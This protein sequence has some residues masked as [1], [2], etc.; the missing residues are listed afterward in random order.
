MLCSFASVI[1]PLLVITASFYFVLL[2]SGCRSTEGI[3]QN[4][5]TNGSSND[6]CMKPSQMRV[7]TT[8][9]LR[10][11]RLVMK[12]EGLSGYIVPSE[13]E[14][15]SEFVPD[16]TKRRQYISGFS[17]SAGMA[18]VLQE[19][20][21]VQTDSRYRVQAAL[22]MDCQWT[23][24]P[25]GA[26][27]VGTFAAMI[28]PDDIARGNNRIGVD[29]CLVT[30]E[31][32]STL[33]GQ[34]EKH[35]LVLVG[36]DS[37]LIDVIWTSGTGR[38]HEPLSPITVHELQYAG[39]TWQ[40]KLGRLREKL[41]AQDIDGIVI[42]A[43][44]E[45]AWLFNLRGSDVPYTPV[46]ESFALIT[47]T[48]AKLYLKRGIRS[49]EEA[50][51]AHL[52]ADCRND[53]EPCVTVMDYNETYQD[54]PR[55]ATKF[56]RILTTF[57]CSYALCGD[58]PKEK[59]VQ[60]DSPVKYFQAIKN[61]VE[62]DGMRNAHLKDAVAQVSMY[63]LLEKDLKK[64]K[65][66]D[67]LKVGKQLIHFRK[68]QKLYRGDSFETI[69]ASGPNSAIVHYSP[70][71]QTNRRVDKDQML[72]VDTGGQYLD[73]TVDLTR[74]WHFGNPTPFQKEAYTRVLMGVIDLFTLTFPQG[75]TGAQVDILA[76]RPLFEAGLMY[77]HGTGHGIGSY[78]AV[79]ESIPRVANYPKP[80]DTAFTPGMFFSIE[81]GFYLVDQ[82]GIRLET[83]ATVVETAPKYNVSGLKF[84]KFEPIAFL[85]FERK[86]ILPE[87]LNTRQVKWLNEYNENILRRVGRELK[88]QKKY[89]AG[90][91]LQKQV[92]IL[93][94]PRVSTSSD[95]AVPA[96][97]PSVT[98]A[99]LFSILIA[100]RALNFALT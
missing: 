89:E 43:L 33:K 49:L 3:Q 87:L 4:G 75:V 36:K 32:Y 1:Q 65:T 68:E 72:L 12:K 14:H 21:L 17:G 13:D 84:F 45:I 46:F 74:T 10:R 88:Q 64:G 19:R 91:W 7:D 34:L 22:Q 77:G 83:T 24:V 16:Y 51:Q 81:P 61:S 78:L 38:P 80:T 20:A 28:P 76:R 92:F 52:N 59:Q 70:T 79:H 6:D 69:A 37:N 40:S 15:Q 11:L 85:P 26:D 18:V 67:E 98:T 60:K 41:S 57:A 97:Y 82:F 55:S 53:T 44:D 73:G 25:E 56:S 39:E 47:Q 94:V 48:E 8:D 23:L 29:T 2:P 50:V 86:L 95:A 93:P 9:I 35:K 66:W 31:Y 62:V 27:L 42:S 63:A 90:E 99:S 30:Q 100:H 96:L 58:I 71:A 54:I 5:S